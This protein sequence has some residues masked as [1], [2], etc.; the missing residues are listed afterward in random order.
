MHTVKAQFIN[1]RKVIKMKILVIA[2]KNL[3]KIALDN[4]IKLYI[5]P[6]LS[7]VQANQTMP[8]AITMTFVEQISFRILISKTLNTLHLHNKTIL[9]G[10]WNQLALR[11]RLME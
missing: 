6:Y 5:T 2:L 9:V 10:I 11:I 3:I 1:R 4:S 7:T 8:S